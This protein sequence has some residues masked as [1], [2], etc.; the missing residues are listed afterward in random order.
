MWLRYKSNLFNAIANRYVIC[1]ESIVCSVN[2]EYNLC[3]NKIHLNKQILS[4]NP[5]CTYINVWRLTGYG[6]RFF[7]W[8]SLNPCEVSILIFAKQKI[9]RCEKNQLQ[10]KPIVSIKKVIK[11]K[12]KK[13]NITKTQRIHSLALQCAWNKLNSEKRKTT[14]KNEQQQQQQQHHQQ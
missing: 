4:Q 9:N 11:S 1:S 5:L 2:Y 13:R 3:I 8:M 14:N 12:K 6:W 10:S 7:S